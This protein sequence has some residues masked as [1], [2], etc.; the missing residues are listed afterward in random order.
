MIGKMMPLKKPSIFKSLPLITV[1]AVLASSMMGNISILA[2]AQ[3]S[4]T[5]KIP[6]VSGTIRLTN[7]HGISTKSN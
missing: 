2:S 1:V 7:R 3:H 5:T 6:I 4:N